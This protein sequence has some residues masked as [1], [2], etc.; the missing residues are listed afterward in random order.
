MN[1]TQLVKWGN[2][3]GIRI[4][5]EDLKKAQA[6]IGE[7][8]VL[9]VNRKGGFTLTPLK[10]SQ[11]GWLEAFNKIADKGQDNVLLDDSIKNKFDEDEWTW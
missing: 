10:S 9:T 7:K 6:Y 5:A 3:A 4:P 2:S 8:F 11:E 1:I